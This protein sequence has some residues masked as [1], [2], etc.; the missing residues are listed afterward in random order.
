[1]TL[2]ACWEPRRMAARPKSPILTCPKW[3]LMKILSHLRSLCMTGGSWLCRYSKPLRI[4]RA[5]FFTALISTRWYFFLYLHYIYSIHVYIHLRKVKLSI[6]SYFYM[7][8]TFIKTNWKFKMHM[9]ELDSV[10]SNVL[11]V[12]VFV[13]VGWRSADSDFKCVF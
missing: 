3:P 8:T 13:T 11:T 9:K 7:D 1:M 6:K 10:P 4:W 12:T 2:C 5:Q